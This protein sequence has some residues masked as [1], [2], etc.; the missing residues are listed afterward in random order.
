VTTRVAVCVSRTGTNLRAL[1]EASRAGRLPIE[2]VLVVA[3]R[4]CPA[5]EWAEEQGLPTAQ[6]TAGDP[7]VLDRGLEAA[8]RHARP[9]VV[10]LA[11]YMRLV[12][13]RTL[14][15]F[16]GR[17]VN[18]HP[19]LLPAFPGAHAV[20]D[21]LAAGVK[22]TGVTVHLVDETLD[23]GP[24]LLQEPVNVEPDDDEASLLARLH[25][26]EQRLLA[27]GLLLVAGGGVSVE[28][29]R[30]RLNPTLTAAA[31]LP[32]RRALLSVSDKAG[33]ADF[34]RGLHELGFELASTGGTA[35]TLRDAGLPVTDVAAVTGFAEMLDGRV[36]TLHPRVHGGILAEQHKPAHRDQ[37]AA[38]A[39]APFALVAVNLYPFA[40]AA[41]RPGISLPELVE[42]I[43]IGGPTLVRAAAKN[44]S[45][46]AVVVSPARYGEVLGELRANRELSESRRAALAIEA[47]RHVA[48][49]DARIA[50]ELPVHM[51]A[52]MAVP[53]EPG[54]PGSADP[55]PRTL[56]LG[57]DK[58]ETLRYGENPH[59]VAALYRRPGTPPE[60]GPFATGADL[61]QGKALSYN[62]V[63]DASAA[64]ALARDL[65]GP[66]CVIVKHTNPCGAAEAGDM[67]AAWELALAG[68]PVSAFGGVVAV[69][70]PVDQ[71]LAQRLAAIFL[72]VVVA[73][74]ITD[75]ARSILGL[76]TNLRVLLHPPL[77]AASPPDQTDPFAQLRSAGGGVLVGS[78][79]VGR[80]D[81]ATWRVATT[82]GPSDEE[83]RDLDLAWR[84]GRHVK[85]NAI[86][87]VRS[88]ALVGVGAGQMSRVDSA[89]LA[90]AKAGDRAPFSACASDAFYPFAD[91]VEV[92]IEAGVRAFV[93]PGGSVR[94][95]EVIAAVDAAG[96]TMLLTGRRHFRH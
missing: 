83:A 37:L 30:T 65:R 8:L 85:S 80:D 18:V 26:V 89:R 95:A 77:A 45:S 66:A 20:G 21:A 87:L 34:A 1:V 53:D 44:F 70:R 33:L 35:A 58:V 63:L 19:S 84:V 64:V 48:A 36:K 79:D 74:A 29:R 52:A 67:L 6:L 27:Q 24:I 75:E 16:S 56:S 71:L 5:L 39:I 91:A 57:L 14:A 12:G 72:E 94:D 31:M 42:E 62:N 7:D 23:A 90:V 41:E 28:G 49:Y 10:L 51:A 43:D 60:R 55:F 54:L 11:G 92:C 69:T 2:V 47:F 73:P 4:P 38:A 40:R 13:P 46:V 15:A 22:T 25:V 93:Q 68:D 88:G 76:K 96:G 78:A 82:R 32:A 86:V 9:K 3:D 17:I 61:I 50:A 59:Q 81:P